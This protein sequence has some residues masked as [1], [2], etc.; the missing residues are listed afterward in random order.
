MFGT[1]KEHI[2]LECKFVTIEQRV[3]M[4]ETRNIVDD[5]TQMR[6]QGFDKPLYTYSEIADRK[7]ISPATVARVAE[8]HGLSRR[9]LKPV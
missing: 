4:L 6:F 7:H 2:K 3:S 1:R 9:S 8:K 5:L